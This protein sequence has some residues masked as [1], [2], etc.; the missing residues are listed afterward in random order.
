[1]AKQL[2]VLIQDFKDGL[3]DFVNASPLTLE[4]KRL[5]IYEYMD[6]V[7]KISTAFIAQERAKEKAESGKV[8]DAQS[9]KEPQDTK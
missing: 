3:A 5:A 2:D 4:I 1:M 6:K 7:T 9:D 8:N